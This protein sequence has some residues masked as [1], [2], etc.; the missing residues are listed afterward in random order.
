MRVIISRAGTG[1]KEKI[2]RPQ[3]SWEETRGQAGSGAEAVTGEGTGNGGWSHSAFWGTNKSGHFFLG[4]SAEESALRV[5]TRVC[6]GERKDTPG[7]CADCVHAA[8]AKGSVR[9]LG[10]A[11]PRAGPQEG[12]R[13]GC[14]PEGRGDGEGTGW[15]VALGAG[16]QFKATAVCRHAEANRAHLLPSC[17]LQPPC[18]VDHFLMP[19]GRQQRVPGVDSPAHA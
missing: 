7:A 13:R 5:G 4:R 17:P 18:L 14:G 2:Q 16:H 9:V 19:W 6:W 11:R 10:G 12:R 8:R 15:V 3:G 1:G